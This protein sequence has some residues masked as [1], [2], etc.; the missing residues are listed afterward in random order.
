MELKD[1]AKRLL[2]DYDAHCP[3]SLFEQPNLKLRVKDAYDLQFEVAALRQLRGERVSGYKIGCIS[4]TMQ[5]QLGIDQPVFGHVWDTELYASGVRLNSSEF[6]GLA[7]E[8]EFAVRLLDDVPSAKW[9]RNN[10]EVIA[11][12]QVV[13]EL[14]NY[15]FRGAESDRAVELI[16]NNAI[17]AGVVATNEVIGH[18]DFQSPKGEQ[19]PDCTPSS[20]SR[21]GAKL[22]V[23]RNAECLGESAADHLQG[24]PLGVVV[25][26]A[27]H[28]ERRGLQLERDQLVLTG[29]PLPLWRLSPGDY[30]TVES[31][32]LMDVSCTID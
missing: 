16:A 30:V 24:D 6:D 32:G 23:H 18:R 7:I 4:D 19:V 12:P 28:L 31:D 20:A 15:V 14:H 26:I 2:K 1:A 22:R 9:L 27:D 3:S 11:G 29:S 21:F 25:A 17:H 10:P 13:I 8:G 5:Q